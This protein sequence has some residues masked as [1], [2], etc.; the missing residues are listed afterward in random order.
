M[1][2]F[3]NLRVALAN[4]PSLFPLSPLKAMATF[5]SYLC[6][7]VPFTVAELLARV[8]KNV[9]VQNKEAE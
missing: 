7:L 6:S 9:Y 2:C 4:A 3:T 8:S 5:Y 1:E